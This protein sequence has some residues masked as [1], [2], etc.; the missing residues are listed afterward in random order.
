MDQFSRQEDRRQG[1]T[2]FVHDDQRPRSRISQGNDDA[3]GQ[4]RIRT[5]NGRP[6]EEHQRMTS[7][8]TARSSPLALGI[9]MRRLASA[10]IPSRQC[11]RF[12]DPR[13]ITVHPLIRTGRGRAADHYGAGFVDRG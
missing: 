9:E 10:T 2:A 12:G 7:S 6:M 8:I 1:S 11:D 13:V 3:D 4:G 5:S